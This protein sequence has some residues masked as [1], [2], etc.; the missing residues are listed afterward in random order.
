MYHTT[1]PPAVPRTTISPGSDG[2]RESAAPVYNGPDGEHGNMNMSY[3]Y[4]NARKRAIRMTASQ[5][6]GDG[7]IIEESPQSQNGQ[8]DAFGRSRAP[9]VNWSNVPPSTQ[10]APAQMI[11]THQIPPPLPEQVK[12]LNSA[13]MGNQNSSRRGAD[14]LSVVVESDSGIDWAA[15]RKKDREERMLERTEREQERAQR[16][17]E[18]DERAQ[19]KQDRKKEREER[20]LEKEERRREREEILRLKSNGNSVA[21]DHTATQKILELER[22]N[23]TLAKELG[24]VKG[25]LQAVKDAMQAERDKASSLV[26]YMMLFQF[27]RFSSI[28]H[29]FKFTAYLLCS[30]MKEKLISTNYA[31]SLPARN[32]R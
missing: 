22:A 6:S 10:I 1:P 18:M 3:Q 25:E 19:E 20:V 31:T 4:D 7:K 9:G 5:G 15:E 17:R 28:C 32:R 26:Q 8:A 30:R 2:G 24:I 29:F 13:D 16:R 11:P 14:Q 21:I 27:V 23:T 12:F